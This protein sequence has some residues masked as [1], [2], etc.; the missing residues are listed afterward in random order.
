MTTPLLFTPITIRDVTLKNRV[1]IAPMA[2]YSAVDGI[3]QDFHFA[4]WGRLVLGGASCVFVEATAVTDQGRITN[5]DMGLWS[6]AHMPPLARI[7]AFM[8][9]QGVV[10]GIQ[11]AH[12]GRKGSMQRP[13]YG[14]GP[15]NAEDLARGE[16]KWDIV[17]PTSEPM[18]EGHIVPRQL[19]VSDLAALKGHWV[20]AAKRALDCGFD[21]LEIHNAHGYLMHQFLSP[22]S[23]KRNDAYGGDF[24]GRTR[25]PLEVAE[26]LRAV[27]PQDK[28]VFLRVS[29]VDGLDGGWT[30]DDTVAYAKELKA[31]GIDVIDCSS[32][33]LYGSATAAR[34]KR[35]WGFQ[36]PYAERVR[37]EAGIMSMAVGLIVDP[38]FAEE[39]LQKGRADLI[40]IAREALVNPCW[41]QMAE[42]ALGRKAADA[43]SDWPVQYGWWLKHR[44]RSIAEIRAD[45]A[46]GRQTQT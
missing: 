22:L 12:A 33:G 46:A 27:W 1:V 41:P 36:V 2:T 23:N 6:A 14:N 19:S 25:F 40:A 13:W 29:A 31:R 26:A 38:F 7:A 39:I 44:E 4:H 24:K 3:A 10:P 9:D 37:R 28:P 15:L 30:M 35:S 21:I 45:E 16:K 5:G 8:K 43:M 42:I 11:L 32:G 20:D 34:V 17:A 18:A